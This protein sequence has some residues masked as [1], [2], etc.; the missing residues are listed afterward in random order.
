M[1]HPT[2]GDMQGDVRSSY[3]H[4]VCNRIGDIHRWLKDYRCTTDE[5]GGILVGGT[6]WQQFGFTRHVVATVKNLF[7]R[8]RT[9]PKTIS[10][11]DPELLEIWRLRIYQI[12]V[13][14]QTILMGG[15]VVGT[16]LI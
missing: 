14:M 10:R 13:V 11:L 12:S 5:D 1:A 8:F 3:W 4:S 6:I 15:N 2:T 7:N 9:P 16:E